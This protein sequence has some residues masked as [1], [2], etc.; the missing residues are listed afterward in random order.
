MLDATDD[1]STPSPIGHRQE[2]ATTEKTSQMSSLVMTLYKM[3]SRRRATKD[4]IQLI[5]GFGGGQLSRT[6]QNLWSSGS[7]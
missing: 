4:A 5:L 1:C 2:F 3:L 6:M 7:R